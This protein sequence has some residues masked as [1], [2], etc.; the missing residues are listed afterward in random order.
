MTLIPG[1]LLDLAYAADLTR[2]DVAPGEASR[3]AALILRH[4][5]KDT[6]GVILARQR[7][8]LE[9]ITAPTAVPRRA[10]ETAV[11][12]SYPQPGGSCAQVA[13][14]PRLKLSDPA[15]HSAVRG[16]RRRTPP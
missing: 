1:H 2:A 15:A 6:P 11:I 9:A 13:A 16:P 3:V 5:P 12:P 4:L 8:L 14:Q 7:A 10:T